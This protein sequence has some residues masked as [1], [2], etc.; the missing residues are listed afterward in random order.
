MGFNEKLNSLRRSKRDRLI[1]GVCAG[2]AE[3]TD[4]PPWLWRAG[5][6]FAAIWAGAGGLLYV[7]LW[8]LMPEADT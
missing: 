5:F 7:I 4:T 1:G 6:V 8:F 3:M 2:F